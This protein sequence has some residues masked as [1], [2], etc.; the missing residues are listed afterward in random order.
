MLNPAS[1]PQHQIKF[2][3]VLGEVEK[4]SFTALQ[5][6]GGHSRLMPSKLCVLDLEEGVR[7]FIV[8]VQRGG[9]DQFR[10]SSDW[11]EVKSVSS[12]F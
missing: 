10:D 7:Y 4:N 6:K 5:G 3:R 12:T 11:L 1:V 9:C 2:Q 8:M